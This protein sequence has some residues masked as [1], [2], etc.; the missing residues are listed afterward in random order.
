MQAEI[1]NNSLF[2]D[3]VMITTLVENY[4]T[5]SIAVGGCNAENAAYT[6]YEM[7]RLGRTPNR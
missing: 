4:K 1:C 7:E 5:V 3:S 2:T 6:N